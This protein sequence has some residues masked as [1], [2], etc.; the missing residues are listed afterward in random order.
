MFILIVLESL[1]NF[2]S[3]V[4]QYS[5]HALWP[6]RKDKDLFSDKILFLVNLIDDT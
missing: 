1:T 6:Q 5:K 3:N 2:E 4:Q